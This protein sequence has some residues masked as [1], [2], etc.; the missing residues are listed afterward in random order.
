[1]QC[2][3]RAHS[4]RKLGHQ[5]CNFGMLRLVASVYSLHV[6]SLSL[7]FGVRKHTIMAADSRPAMPLT[8]DSCRSIHTGKPRILRS[9]YTGLTHSYRS[10]VKESTTLFFS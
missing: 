9:L 10:E 2:N 5:M 8:P 3:R 7:Y 1:M 6:C 4:A